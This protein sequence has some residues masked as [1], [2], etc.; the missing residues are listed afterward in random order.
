M[1]FR[2]A[3]AACLTSC[4]AAIT[5]VSA[6]AQTGNWDVEYATTVDGTHI[7]GNPDAEISLTE[8]VSYSCS[9]CSSFTK[10]SEADIRMLLIQPGK[11]R[12]EVRHV[13]RN[14][15]DL[16]AALLTECGPDEKFFANH[17]LFMARHDDWMAK[18]V[19]AGQA[20][21]QRW[22]TG[23]FGARM[24]A[25]AG[26]LD[27]YE[28]MEPR[29]YSRTE[30]DRCL[31][32]EAQGRVLATRSQADGEAFGI[33]GTPSF[34]LNGKVLKDVHDWNGLRQAINAL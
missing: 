5:A 25:I 22:F 18:A 6:N 4:L 28:M 31:S 12:V 13:I 3:L 30:M 10:Q 21:Q 32:D 8:F 33:S 11:M 19:I 27:F 24:R 29:G 20:Q 1:H 16:A 7:V 15:V 17:R 2:T 23:A 26:D 9:H 34:A 14:P